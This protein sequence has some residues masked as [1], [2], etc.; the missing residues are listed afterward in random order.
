[1]GIWGKIKLWAR[2]DELPVL[3]TLP[4]HVRDMALDM[5]LLELQMER[6]IHE[7]PAVN[8]RPVVPR[9]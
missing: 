9:D 4:A 1:M 2:G 8:S 6:S 3:K 7:N 5:G